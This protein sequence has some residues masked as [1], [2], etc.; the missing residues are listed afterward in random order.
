MLKQHSGITN[1]RINML[2]DLYTHYLKNGE[3]PKVVLLNKKDKTYLSYR[4]FAQMNFVNFECKGIDEYH[5]SLL[6]L[7]ID[8]VKKLN[9]DN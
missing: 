2:I 8:K 5:I 9:R 7:G 1:S 4:Y 6:P 3:K